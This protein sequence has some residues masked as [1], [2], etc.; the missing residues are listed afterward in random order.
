MVSQRP[1]SPAEEAE[2]LKSSKRWFESTHGYKNKYKMLAQPQ[3]LIKSL[4]H[5]AGIKMAV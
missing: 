2:D 1:C 4:R 3:C 5:I